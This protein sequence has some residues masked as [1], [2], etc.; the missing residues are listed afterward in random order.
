M[1][2]TRTYG[3]LH[4]GDLEPHRFEDLIRQLAFEHRAWVRIEATGRSGAERGFDIR[5]EEE[6]EGGERRTWMFQCKREK[7]VGPSA[8]KKI[9]ADTLKDEPRPHVFV[10]VAPTDL[11]LRTRDVVREEAVKHGLQDWCVFRPS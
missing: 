11:S 4:F 2:V 9:M 7:K 1:A 3:P 6:L 5:A 8:A 10:L